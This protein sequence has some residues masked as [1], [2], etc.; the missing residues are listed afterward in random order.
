MERTLRLDPRW[1][2]S[3][4]LPR[5]LM[6]DQ[7]PSPRRPL[8]GKDDHRERREWSRLSQLVF[9]FLGYMAVL[10]YIGW[11]LDERYGWKGNGL[12]AGLMLGLGAWIYRVLRIYRNL[13]K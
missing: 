3:T 5:P 1:V 11:T 7:P 12:F 2:S 13:F 6:S 10:G 8:P 9:E 4:V